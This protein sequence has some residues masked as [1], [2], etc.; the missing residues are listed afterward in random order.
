[1]K[2]AFLVWNAGFWSVVL[3]SLCVSPAGAGQS[4]PGEPTLPAI[5]T[6]DF[7][8]AQYDYLD[9]GTRLSDGQIRE[10]LFLHPR[11]IAAYLAEAS[12]S[13]LNIAPLFVLDAITDLHPPE[14]GCWPG[15]SDVLIDVDEELDPDA[16][17]LSIDQHFAIVN[18]SCNFNVSTFGHETG[19]PTSSSGLV[20]MPLQ[21]VTAKPF[22]TPS[23]T[24]STDFSRLTQS[25]WAHEIG[26]GLGIALHP[27]TYKCDGPWPLSSDP[28]DCVP[29]ASRHMHDV[30]G[31][32]HGGTH[33]N[34]HFKDFFGWIPAVSKRTLSTPGTYVFDL[35]DLAQPVPPGETQFVEIEL[36]VPVP[37]RKPSSDGFEFDKLT[38]EFRGHTGFDARPYKTVPL[39]AGG[40]RNVTAVVN[41][42]GVLVQ[43]LECDGLAYDWSPCLPYEID[44]QPNSMTDTNSPDFWDPIDGYLLDGES[45]V[46]PLN[47]ITVRVL[48][49]SGAPQSIQV[50]VT[51]ASP[52][53]VPLL[54]GLGNW[55]LGA[56]LLVC[57]CLPL[58]R[59]ALRASV[60]SF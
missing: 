17:W 32:R 31:E 48:D 57:G 58:T 38:L 3:L 4:T 50:E 15:Q 51:I 46:V 34:G 54:R 11:S 20:Y 37:F 44:M 33:L 27:T 1:M 5:G 53:P 47:G 26:H 7:S 13:Q 6:R 23:G 19:F 41:A 9:D 21:R 43:A 29:S 45:F 24:L 28:A 39:A 10:A 55:V 60:T 22:V 2:G 30:M 40:S 49:T 42:Y 59:R 8:V 16:D 25:T 52:P 18:N 36:A 12:Y 35:H 56:G 14:G